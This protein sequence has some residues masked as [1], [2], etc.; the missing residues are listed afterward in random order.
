MLLLTDGL[1]NEGVQGREGILGEMRKLQ[2]PAGVQVAQRT[3]KTEEGSD[4]AQ[5]VG[6]CSRPWLS[7]R[8]V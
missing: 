8:L 2:E 7:A 1:A 3:E 5:K 6:G 4:V